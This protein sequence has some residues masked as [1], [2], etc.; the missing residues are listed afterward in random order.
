MK[1]SN[2]VPIQQRTGSMDRSTGSLLHVFNKDQVTIWCK[3]SSDMFHTHNQEVW[4]ISADK[5]QRRVLASVG[6][7]TCEKTTAAPLL[8]LLLLPPPYLL[9]ILPPSDPLSP[10][11]LPVGWLRTPPEW[12]LQ[13]TQPIVLGPLTREP[14]LST[15]RDLPAFCH[16]ITANPL[17]VAPP[18]KRHPPLLAP[19]TQSAP[20]NMQRDA[21]RCIEQSCGAEC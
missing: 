13:I 21:C 6:E 14:L 7:S 5:Q 4:S 3:M 20:L 15:R 10:L 8:L 17:K 18:Y 12:H 1:W 9:F 19:H 16:I 11:S 2:M